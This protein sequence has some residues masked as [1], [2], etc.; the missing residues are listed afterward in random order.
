ML[1]AEW[2][3]QNDGCPVPD[4]LL[5]EIHRADENRV[6][7]LIATVVPSLRTL[8]ALYCYQRSHLHTKGLLIAARC[9]Q[10]DLVR[11]GGHVGAFLF[12]RSRET[13]SPA[14]VSS[15]VRRRTVTLST[16]P[17]RKML[18]LVDDRDQE[19]TESMQ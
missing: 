1:Q 15:F 3:H 18:R 4:E 6:S 7:D 10:D 12:E 11:L 2:A 13:P 17:L 8:L 16:G 19:E 5:G 14:V 9:D